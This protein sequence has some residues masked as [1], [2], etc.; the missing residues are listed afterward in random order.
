[1]SYEDKR[2]VEFYVDIKY[3]DFIHNI[4]IFQL[5]GIRKTL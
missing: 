4:Q 5:L 1:M 2:V 3:L